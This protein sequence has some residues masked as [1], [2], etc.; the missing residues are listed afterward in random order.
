VVFSVPPSK[1]ADYAGELQHA[2][3]LWTGE[4]AFVFTSSGEHAKDL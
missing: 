1:E 3:K 4:G 2:L